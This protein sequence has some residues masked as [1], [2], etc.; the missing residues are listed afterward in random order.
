MGLRNVL[1]AL[2]LGVIQGWL[3]VFFLNGPLLHA[4]ADKGDSAEIIFLSFMLTHA[5][6]FLVIW[7]T[8]G[9][10][11]SFLNSRRVLIL[12][13][14]AM[15]AGP[16]LAGA[17]MEATSNTYGFSLVFAATGVAAIGG[18][19][20][21]SAW[22]EFFSKLSTREA[23]LAYG[24]SVITGT[25]L[26]FLSLYLTVIVA[27]GLAALLPAISLALLLPEK[28]ALR[29]SEEG[30]TSTVEVEKTIQRPLPIRLVI[31]VVVFY[32]VGGFFN[33]LLYVSSPYP[34]QESFWIT[35][36]AY[37]GVAVL[38]ALVLFHYPDMDL[39]FLYRPALPLLGVG[40]L[41]FP[42]LHA[43][44]PL[45]PF[46]LFQGGFAL[47]DAYTW[48][49]FAYLASCH[50]K[51]AAVFGYGLFLITG[52]ILTGELA[53]TSLFSIAT[54]AD[55]TWISIAG[56]A[57]MLAATLIFQDSPETFAGWRLRANIVEVFELAAANATT[58]EN[59]DPATNDALERFCPEHSLTL[60]EREIILLLI[61]GR[62]NP[63]IREQ[64]NISNNT[65]KTHLRNLYRK[66]SVSN[67]QELLSLFT[68][69]NEFDKDRI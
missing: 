12:S 24:G 64:L 20:T 7:R 39:R 34:S 15:S 21:V 4:A 17:A 6:S 31:A 67:R 66:L 36:V 52:S 23:A 47:F 5:L 32:L 10:F 48:L 27:F 14:I 42:T 50:E 40:F 69:F 56:A 26:F 62:N 29:L 37:G 38:A 43:L 30:G 22:G 19:I 55:T 41:L 33:K 3:W 54:S 44:A 53:F 45:V 51:P 11:S 59:G 58:E 65:L 61:K 18:A 13:A 9:R 16:A 25:A 2:G 68:T 60:R 8:S 57:S 35:N 63:F 1:R 28:G 49:L 46:A